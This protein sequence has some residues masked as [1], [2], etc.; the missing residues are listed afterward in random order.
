MVAAQA[1]DSQAYE[2]L[3]ELDVWLRRYYARRLPRAVA[4]DAG[5]ARFSPSTPRGT[6]ASSKPFGPWVAAIARY[7]WIVRSRRRPVRSAIA[8]R[9]HTGQ[10]SRGGCDQRRCSGRSALP[11]KPAQA[12][13]IRLVKLEASV[14]KALPVQLGNPQRSSKSTS[15][16]V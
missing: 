16:E 15:I 9:R 13:V 10:G 5:K 1:G 4:E 12:R 3:L 14:S 6:H 2:Q 11:A 8:P 7:K